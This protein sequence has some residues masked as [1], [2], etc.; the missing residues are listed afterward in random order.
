MSLHTKHMELLEA[1]NN[2]TTTGGHEFAKAKLRGFREALE[3]IG[4]LYLCECDKFYLDKGVNRP[5][6]AGVFLDWVP[7]A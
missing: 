6:V 4:E 1:V 5:M 2:S 3:E 7:S